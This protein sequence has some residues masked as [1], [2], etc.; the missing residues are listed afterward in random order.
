MVLI[1]WGLL[2]KVFPYCTHATLQEDPP[3]RVCARGVLCVFPSRSWLLAIRSS[4]SA[5]LSLDC[6]S[7]LIETAAT[8]HQH[9][10][11]RSDEAGDTGS[12]DWSRDRRCHVD[13]VMFVVGDGSRV[14]D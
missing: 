6:S 11:A 8:E 2:C 3:A 12:S 1:A 7:P 13:P 9:S 5:K 10:S 4:E 14:V